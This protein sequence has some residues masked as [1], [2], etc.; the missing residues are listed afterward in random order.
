MWRVENMRR[1]RI[2]AAEEGGLVTSHTLAKVVV[3]TW[4]EK[5]L[6]W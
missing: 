5:A 4:V 3:L 6:R 2:P 1:Q